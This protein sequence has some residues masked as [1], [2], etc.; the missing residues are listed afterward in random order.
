MSPAQLNYIVLSTSSYEA[1]L[2]QER[3]RIVYSTVDLVLHLPLAGYAN[4]NT[5]YDS[6]YERITSSK[7]YVSTRSVQYVVWRELYSSGGVQQ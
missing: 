3:K 2:C 4:F 6:Q 1:Q 7:E 5:S